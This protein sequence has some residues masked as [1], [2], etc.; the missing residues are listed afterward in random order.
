VRFYSRHVTEL[1]EIWARMLVESGDK[2]RAAG[3]HD[4]ADF[5]ALKASND[6][7]RRR[8]VAWLLQTVI[9]LA[10][11]ANRANLPVEIEREDP[12]SFRLQGANMVGI[13][14]S[15]RHGVRCLTIEAGWTRTPS[16]G[17]MRGGALA[18]ARLSHFGLK[19]HNTELAL[20]KT[21]E[22]PEWFELRID[23]SSEIFGAESV[24][25]HF[26]LLVDRGAGSF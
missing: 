26:G 7:I 21:E 13:K 12:H 20:R 8:A 11:E 4:I 10:A 23:G 9:E 25:R 3:R 22:L 2:A 15:F 18:M 24:K 19:E 17:F 1:D 16:D 6:D 5:L 14:T